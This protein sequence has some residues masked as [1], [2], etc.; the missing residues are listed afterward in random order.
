MRIRSK[1]DPHLAAAPAK[2][3]TQETATVVVDLM[4]FR[5]AVRPEHSRSSLVTG[6]SAPVLFTRYMGVFR[7]RQH[8]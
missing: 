6:A 8:R 2:D 5:V 3:V 7:S 4:A 1:N